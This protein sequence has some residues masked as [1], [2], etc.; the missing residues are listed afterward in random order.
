[1]AQK[2]VETQQFLWARYYLKL[3][4]SDE[5]L[6]KQELG[7]RAYWFP[8]EQNQSFSR[9]HLEKQLGK[10]WKTAIGFTY[11]VKSNHYFPKTQN[12]GNRAEIRPQLE[13]AFSQPLLKKLS[14]HHRYW[15][16]FRFFE[17]ADR[18]LKFKNYRFRYKLELRYKILNGLT[19]MAFDEIFVNMGEEVVQNVFDQNRFGLSVLYAPFKNF[20]F[21]LGYINGFQQKKSGADFNNDHIFRFTIHHKISFV[22]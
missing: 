11:A 12:F 5:W 19:I 2:N 4:I 13:L 21:E 16:E 3:K 9:S 15:F 8:W 1:M 14:L 7:Q 22:K 20:G 6:V 10:N 18:L 17:Q